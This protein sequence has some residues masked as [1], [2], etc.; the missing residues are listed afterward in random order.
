MVVLP[1]EHLSLVNETELLQ[2]A[3]A[4]RADGTLRV[5]LP[6]TDPH[7]VLIADGGSAFHAGW[8]ALT[9]LA[10]VQS[11]G[12]TTATCAVEE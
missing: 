12:G 4:D 5:P 8:E 1:A 6:S 10:V 11:T 7:N 3:S 2:R 9:G